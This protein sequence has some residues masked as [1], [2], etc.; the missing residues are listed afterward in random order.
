MA[1]PNADATAQS[2][3]DKMDGLVDGQPLPYAIVAMLAQ[4]KIFSLDKSYPEPEGANTGSSRLDQITTL[5]KVLTRTWEGPDGKVYDLFDAVM[6][7]LKWVLAEAPSL[8][9]TETG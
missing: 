7:I 9:A 5:A 8:N 4:S 1:S 3:S 6:S 2:V